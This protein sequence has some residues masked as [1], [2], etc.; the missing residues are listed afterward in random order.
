[1]SNKTMVEINGNKFEVDMDTAR[2]IDTYNI[3]DNVKV[4][5]KDYAGFHVY[6]G[7]IIDFVNFKDLPTIQIAM[8]EDGYKGTTIR[9]V[10]FNK[11]TE[12]FEIVPA[13]PHELLLEKNSVIEKFD[14]AIE[15]KKNELDELTTKRDWF[16][17]Y[18]AKYF[19]ENKSLS[20]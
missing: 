1:M 13:S 12:N 14:S 17:K 19:E 6:P 10:D 3:G 15:A 8:L 5:S 2:R 18:F 20:E 16:I 7:I 4:L 9:F 11:N